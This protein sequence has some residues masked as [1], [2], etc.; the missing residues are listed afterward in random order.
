VNPLRR[1]RRFGMFSF[2]HDESRDAQYRAMLA[3]QK[4]KGVL[5]GIHMRCAAFWLPI[6]QF[7]ELA[8]P[9]AVV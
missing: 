2:L 8:A 9:I 5:S 7:L 1:G 3:Q 4:A 6:L